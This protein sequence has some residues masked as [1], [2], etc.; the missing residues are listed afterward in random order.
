MATANFFRLNALGSLSLHRDGESGT[1][2]GVQKRRLG[3]LAI[4]AAAGKRGLSRDRIQSF[5]WPEAD[6]ARS[7]HALDQLV[8]ARSMPIH[9][10]PKAVT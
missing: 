2:T 6:P 8:Y 3:L 5:I 10:S 7:R 4:L 1:P 9:S